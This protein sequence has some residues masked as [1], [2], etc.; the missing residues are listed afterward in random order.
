[1]LLAQI[2]DSLKKSN[3]KQILLIGNHV[4]TNIQI[5]NKL[6]KKIRKMTNV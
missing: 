6:H 4:N 1:M 5:E 3:S 2:I